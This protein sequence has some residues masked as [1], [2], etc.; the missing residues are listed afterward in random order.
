MSRSDW[1][2]GRSRGRGA[3]LEWLLLAAG[4]LAALSGC[5]GGSSS[6]TTAAVAAAPSNIA[7]V[8]VNGGPSG[9]AQ[10]VLYTTVTLCAPGSTTECQT[11]D[12]I[13]IDTASSG[14]R[15]ISSVLGQG[16]TIAE[17][18][19]VNG[20]NGNA[21]VE[22]TQFADGYSWGS[23]KLADVSIAGEAASS[24]PIQVIGDPAYPATLASMA[25]TSNVDIEEDTVIQFGANGILG[26][27]GFEQDCG[28][29]CPDDG[30]AYNDC[31]SN[32]CVPDS[33]AVNL[34]VTNPDFLFATDNNGVLIQVTAASSNTT[35]VTGTMVFGIGTQTNNALSSAVTIYTLDPNA[36][37]FT[38]VFAGQTLP[39]SIVDTGSSAYY[40]PSGTDAPILPVCQDD[41]ELYCPSTTQY[42]QGAPL[43][44]T[45]QG[46]NGTLA[47]VDFTVGNG[48]TLNRLIQADGY[49][50]VPTLGATAGNLLTTF[51]WGL[52]F[53]YGRPV[54]VGNQGA[55]ISGQT[56]PLI[57]F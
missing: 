5:G 11:I 10:N 38:T 14:F 6:D 4:V 23:V 7:T 29:D 18:T 56:G 3:G 19:Q 15:V 43:Q 44:G 20:T 17:L 13:Q 26:V 42:P 49:T 45:I 57:A 24:V 54:Y 47:N 28:A 48:D 22:C 36:G 39:D 37:T 16:L 21:L 30:S 1:T 27:Q 9:N 50:V 33:P 51:D 46:G 55:T 53:F 35:S 12:N 32:S 34:Q 41:T 40:F 25:C 2:T 52:P 8:A 31:T